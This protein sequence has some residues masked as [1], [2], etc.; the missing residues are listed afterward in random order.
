MIRFRAQPLISAAWFALAFVAL[1]VVYRGLFNGLNRGGQVLL[2]LPSRRLPEPI[3]HVVLLGPI[4]TEGLTIA[5]RSA[6]P[7]ALIILGFGLINAILNVPGLVARVSHRGPLRAV[8]QA[9]VIAWATLPSLT[10]SVRD[11][12]RAR[13]LRGERG[14]AALLVPVMEQTLERAVALGTSMEVR[15]FAADPA[16]TPPAASSADREDTPTIEFSDVTLS[17]G[18][19]WQVQADLAL[20]SGQLAVLLGPTGSGKSTLLHA[21]SG[22]HTHVYAGALSGTLTLNGIDRSLSPHRTA[23]LVGVV[24]QQPRLSFVAETVREEIGF[25]SR[26]QGTSRAEIERRVRVSAERVGVADLLDAATATLSAGQAPLV[27]IAAAIAHEPL[28]LLADEPLADLDAASRVRV[29]ALLKDLAAQGLTVVVAE[30]RTTD[31]LTVADLLLTLLPDGED[32]LRVAVTTASAHHSP[33]LPALPT[34]SLTSPPHAAPQTT[35]TVAVIRDARVAYGA[36]T[37]V[38]GASLTV[39]SGEIVAITGDVGSGKTSLLQAIALPRAGVVEVAGTDVATLSASKRVA[40]LALVPDLSDDLLFALTVEQECARADRAAHAAR[41]TT[42]QR[43]VGFLSR[44][45][46]SP[47][48]RQRHPR[49]L[50]VGQRRLLVLAVQLAH[51]PRLLL[52]DEP[53]RGLDAASADSV[54]RALLTTAQA[55]T[56]VLLATH[57]PAFAAIAHSR[58]NLSAGAL[59]PEVSA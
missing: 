39:M 10:M 15:G 37:V 1:R 4:T 49:D 47:E 12:R 22:L 35:T 55:G 16:P 32:R 38:E 9:L 43:F 46:A 56:G 19:S 29:T 6:L 20:S 54:R 11:V 48:L 2:D 36:R 14:L 23:H 27:A 30:H 53:S 28:V 44:S 51:S 52:I 42:L 24:A 59:S 3:N 50:S 13:S 25:A 40:A 31:L 57:D 45:A 41:G 26:V 58:L 17:Y 8:P 33:S 7:I 5:V 18:A 21:I 34:A